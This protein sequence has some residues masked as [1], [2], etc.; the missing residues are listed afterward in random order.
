VSIIAKLKTLKRVELASLAFYAVSG[1]IQLALLPFAGFPPHVALIGILSLVAAYSLFTNRGWTQ[2]LVAILF[3]I[4]SVFAFYTLYFAGF[5]NLLLGLGLIAYVALAW[6]FALY[7]L[8]K[9]KTA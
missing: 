2:W 6:V 1:I 9:R 4:A 3:I 8:F 5:S 7:I